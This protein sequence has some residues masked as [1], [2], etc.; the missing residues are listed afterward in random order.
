MCY[1]YFFPD[2]HVKIARNLNGIID[3]GAVLLVH[4]RQQHV[5][6]ADIRIV[7]QVIMTY[8]DLQDVAKLYVLQ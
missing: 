7:G 6:L 5:G 1:T 3:A 8:S 2:P 4:A